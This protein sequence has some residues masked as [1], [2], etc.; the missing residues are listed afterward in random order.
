M[1]MRKPCILMRR[2]SLQVGYKAT[3]PVFASLGARTDLHIALEVIGKETVEVPAGKFDCYKVHL[4]MVNQDFWFSDDMHRYL[5]KFEAGPITAE[6]MSIT[7]RRPAEAVAF[8]DAKPARCLRPR[9]L[10]NFPSST[11]PTGRGGLDPHTRSGR[12]Y[13]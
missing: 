1:T 9:G 13:L 5:V 10:G 3:V 4:N 7:Q 11:R 12:G 6:L 8:H 2:L